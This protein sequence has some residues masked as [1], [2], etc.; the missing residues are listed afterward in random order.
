M[1]QLKELRASVHWEWRKFEEI[2]PDSARL[3]RVDGGDSLVQVFS[4]QYLGIPWDVRAQTVLTSLIG[5]TSA[6]EWGS[7]GSNYLGGTHRARMEFE[8]SVRALARC[9]SAVAFASGWA[10]NYAVSEALGRTCQVVISDTRSHNSVIHGLRSAKVDLHVS[11]L[12][13]C[14]W[15]NILRKHSSDRIGLFCPSVEGISGEAVQ[16]IIPPEHRSRIIWAL[17]ECHTFGAIGNTGYE[18]FDGMKPDIR[19]LGLSKACGTMGSVVCGDKDFMELLPQLAS[20][21]MF[22]TAVPPN[23]WRI[24]LELVRFVGQLKAERARILELANRLRSNLTRASVHGTGKHHITGILIAPG[25][26]TTFES[27]LRCARFY[28]KV[29]QYPS[30][31]RD[32]PAVRVCFTPFH[33]HE[34]VDDFSFAIKNSSSVLRG[35]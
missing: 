28:A 12:A 34:D 15:H 25:R 27:E 19:V 4:T 23:I 31:P 5:T 16:P 13:C 21:W 3:V 29:S 26:A 18:S 17:D 11:D 6:S 22:S 9:E 7:F 8:D 30:R 2:D 20:P 33:T 10:A 1:S 24:N 32:N 14:E 35:N